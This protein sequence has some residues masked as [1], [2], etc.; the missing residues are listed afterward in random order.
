MRLTYPSSSSA[1]THKGD[2]GGK[3]RSIPEPGKEERIMNPKG[4]ELDQPWLLVASYNGSCQGSLRA[5]FEMWKEI[6]M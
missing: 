3:T 6:F 1:S 5:S 4:M 2:V